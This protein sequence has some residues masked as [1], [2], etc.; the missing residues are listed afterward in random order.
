MEIQSG[1]N[2]KVMHQTLKLTISKYIGHLIPCAKKTSAISQATH[3]C[4]TSITG[5]DGHIMI[6]F[7]ITFILKMMSPWT[8]PPC[9]HT[10]DDVD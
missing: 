3:K 5:E 6:W 4:N 10:F 9:I 1:I 8:I 2:L 7:H